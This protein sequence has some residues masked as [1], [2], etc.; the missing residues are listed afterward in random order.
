MLYNGKF[1]FYQLSMLFNGN[2]EAWEALGETD[3][4]RD[5]HME[6][7]PCVLQD[8]GPLG[9]LPKKTDQKM[10]DIQ[11]DKSIE[12]ARFRTFW[13]MVTDRRTVGCIVR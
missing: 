10:A 2:F 5:R 6:I 8:I 4:R 3:R 13:L 1:A 11:M 9:P 12:N 7:H